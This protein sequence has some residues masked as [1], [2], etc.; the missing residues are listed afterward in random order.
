MHPIFSKKPTPI[1]TGDYGEPGKAWQV[2]FV[3]AFCAPNKIK[4]FW[5]VAYVKAVRED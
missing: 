3:N 2:D 5:S 1:W 4:G